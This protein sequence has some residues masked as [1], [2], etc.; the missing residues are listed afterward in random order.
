[1]PDTAGMVIE[2]ENPSRRE[3]IGTVPRHGAEDVDRAVRAAAAAFGAWRALPALERGVR[4]LRIAEDLS[5]IGEELARTIAEETGNAI[6]TQARGEAATA[7]D[8][9]RYFG[10]VASEQK[11]E[12]L[13]LGDGLFSYTLREPLGVV[14]A[15]VPW[16]APVLLASLKVAMALC[17]GN[18]LVLKP[19][20]DA[21]LGVLKMAEVCWRHLPEGVLN[22]VTGYGEETGGAL[23]NHP[24]IAKITFTGSTE[25]GRIAMRAAAERIL[26]VSLE[27]G[28]KA[29][30]IVYPDSDDD[31]TVQ[32]VITAMRFARQ[33]QSCTAGSRL[34]VHASIFEAFTAKLAAA[35][36]TLVVGDA[37]D[38]AS[39]IGSL[40]NGTQDARVCRFVQ[41]AL[42]QGAVA[43]TGGLPG[44]R[45]GYQ[46]PPTVLTGV[47]QSWR[48]AREEVFG[49]VLVAMPWE[50]EAEVI[51]WANDTHYGLAAF[52]F[53][54]DIER[55]LRAAHAIEAGWVQVNRSGGQLPGMSYG[56]K[57]LSGLGSEY[58][59]EGA[60]ESFTQRKSITIGLG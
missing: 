39:D 15:I 7:A 3:V 17:T 8:V 32:H 57:K 53:C 38:E 21:P 60:L 59:I 46:L 36:E 25:V 50:D 14:A 43:L 12:T 18:T 10:G 31:A 58:S 24:G 27:L 16:N 35:L 11:G 51:R 41:E 56:G 33:G 34:F 42:D 6:R 30:A 26:P 13:P 9:F 44:S 1:M 40:I 54:R 19:A 2:V 52:V 23:L 22:V 4:L 55:A 28:G 49:P 37:L 48:V 5:A 29:P 47:E 45:P 20:E